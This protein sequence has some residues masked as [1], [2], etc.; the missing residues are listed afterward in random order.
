MVILSLWSFDTFC[1]MLVQGFTIR[2]SGT[3]CELRV[4]IRMQL[5]SYCMRFWAEVA[6]VAWLGSNKQFTPFLVHFSI[7]SCYFQLLTEQMLRTQ[8]LKCCG[9]LQ[10]TVSS[11]FLCHQVCYQHLYVPLN[12][13]FLAIECILCGFLRYKCNLG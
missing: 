10:W 11:V 12:N 4:F 6:S 13:I 8:T 7:I 5:A 1:E 3:L 2:R 9:T